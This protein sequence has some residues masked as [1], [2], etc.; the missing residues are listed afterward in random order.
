VL[1]AFH[2]EFPDIELDVFDVLSENC[3]ESVRSGRADIAIAATRVDTPELGAE[4]FQT[5]EF[6]LVA[7]RGHPLLGRANLKPRD[8]LPFDSVN[9]PLDSSVRQRLVAAP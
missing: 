2:A 1:A 3:I 4:P 7:R 5:D 8:L 9:V 6:F